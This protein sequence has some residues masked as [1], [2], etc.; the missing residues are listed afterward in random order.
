ML[1]AS[2]AVTTCDHVILN[3]LTMGI[4]LT[5]L[6]HL[7]PKDY[8]SVTFSVKREIILC[9]GYRYYKY[10]HCIFYMIRLDFYK[11]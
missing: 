11:V 10:F 8:I 2:G 1:I 3:Y 6:T 9:V 4:T 7:Q 5:V